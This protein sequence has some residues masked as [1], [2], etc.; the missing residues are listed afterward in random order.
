MIED[1]GCSCRRTSRAL[2]RM[3]VMQQEYEETQELVRRW[4]L[5]NRTIMLNQKHRDKHTRMPQFPPQD[6]YR[7]VR[8]DHSPVEARKAI[9]SARRRDL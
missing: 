3:K 7:R 2:L 9:L 5:A 6:L 1:Q 8:V 4:H